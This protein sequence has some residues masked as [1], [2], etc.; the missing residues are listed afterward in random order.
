MYISLDYVLFCTLLNC[1]ASKVY[2]IYMH[3][4]LGNYRY[5]YKYHDKH[6]EV[7]AGC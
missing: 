1:C 4:L 2:I 7:V 6:T 3:M 5:K